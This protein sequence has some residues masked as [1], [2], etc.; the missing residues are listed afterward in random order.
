M[1]RREF[2]TLVGGAAATWPLA[3]RAQ[4]P[5]RMRLVAVLFSSSSDENKSN[6]T[7]F[8]RAIDGLGWR[9]GRDIRVGL[10]CIEGGLRRSE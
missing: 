7:I 4:Q 1:K 5:G 3:A 2:I 6:I 8:R 9:E 10:R